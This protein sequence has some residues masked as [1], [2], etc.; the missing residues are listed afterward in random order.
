MS[1]GY[2]LRAEPTVTVREQ[3]M[4][5][6]PRFMVR[7]SRSE[8]FRKQEIIKVFVTVAL[9]SETRRWGERDVSDCYAI[10]VALP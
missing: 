6:L 5:S 10:I 2:Y 8:I 9:H 3:Y 4:C 1:L 7:L